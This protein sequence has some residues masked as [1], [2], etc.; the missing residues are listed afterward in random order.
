MS[1][2]DT[3]DKNTQTL[4]ILLTACK[5]YQRNPMWSC[6]TALST[7]KSCF[8]RRRKAKQFLWCNYKGAEY[9]QIKK[10]FLG[11]SQGIS[12]CLMDLY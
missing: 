9:R 4:Q 7:E 3:K 5:E 10:N 1:V 6:Y 12:S 8:E 2:T 11:S